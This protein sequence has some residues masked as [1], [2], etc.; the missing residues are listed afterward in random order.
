[1]IELRWRA[2]FVPLSAQVNTETSIGNVVK[3]L[4][5]RTRTDTTPR[6]PWMDVPTVF[7][8]GMAANQHPQDQDILGGIPGGQGL[9]KNNL[10]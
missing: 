2:V 5:Y 10:P 6:T 8:E 4:Q 9:T 7:D 3:I 1:M